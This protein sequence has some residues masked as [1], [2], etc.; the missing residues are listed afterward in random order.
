MG[1]GVHP[2]RCLSPA[3][4]VADIGYYSKHLKINNRQHNDDN[5]D[6]DDNNNNDDDNNNNNNAKT[7]F[8]MFVCVVSPQ[9]SH[10]LYRSKHRKNSF[11]C[12]AIK[13]SSVGAS[14]RRAGM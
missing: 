12:E 1:S 10:I 14:E 7:C 9:H 2:C 3:G 8:Q 6:D 5:N 13:G 11:T 4:G